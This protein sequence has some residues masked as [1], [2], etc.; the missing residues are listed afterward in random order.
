ML[1]GIAFQKAVKHQVS[2]MEEY[3]GFQQYFFLALLPGS[4]KTDSFSRIFLGK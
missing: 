4:I 2:C 1:I 3:T